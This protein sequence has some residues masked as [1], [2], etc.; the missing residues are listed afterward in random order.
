MSSS[1][2]TLHALAISAARHSRVPY[3]KQPRGAALLLSDG[4]WVPGVRVESASFSSTIPAVTAAISAAV[5]IGRHDIVAVALSDKTRSDEQAFLEEKLLRPITETVL[6]CKTTLPSPRAMLD[7]SISVPGKFTPMC[8]IKMARITAKNSLCPLSQFP[9][10]CVIQTRSGKLVAGVN[11]E[12]PDWVRTICAERSALA[13]AL[14]SGFK[15][16]VAVYATCLKDL[17][18][19]SCGACRQLLAEYAPH[20][21]VWMDRG[22]NKPEKYTVSDLLPAAFHGQT[23]KR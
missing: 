14:S 6:A 1:A 17:G 18:G 13:I 19:T 5:A 4:T 8:G 20:A 2:D 12:H 7:C 16:F 11:V 9:V 23:L 10:G 21:S 3:S 15:D 22:N